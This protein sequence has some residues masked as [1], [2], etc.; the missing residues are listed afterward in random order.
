[1]VDEEPVTQV[2]LLGDQVE[3]WPPCPSA[4]NLQK[5]EPDFGG[6]DDDEAVDEPEGG[7]GGEADQPEPDED[8]NLLV[9][10]VDGEHTH[11]VVCLDRPGRAELPEGA[12]G[13]PGKDA[14]H[15]VDSVLGIHIG[16]VDDLGAVRQEGAAQ[17]EVGEVDIAYHHH[18]T[19]RLA[20]EEPNCPVHVHVEVS[21]H[22]LREDF[23]LLESCV[24]VHG[25]LI[26][27]RQNGG[28]Q[29]SFH[30]LP[31]VPRYI[32]H[33]GLQHQN[34]RDPLVVCVIHNLIFIFV[35]SYARVGYAVP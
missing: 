1:M 15:G 22:I 18:Q 16:E 26:Q 23:V 9:D 7:D 10:D 33:D 30:V 32:E 8:V 25:Q 2:A 28:E 5:P 12:L 20:Q 19:Q 35:R 29:A 6:G 4:T 17:E 3:V 21:D 24:L 31:Q 27:T 34:K 13:D 14:C 11:G